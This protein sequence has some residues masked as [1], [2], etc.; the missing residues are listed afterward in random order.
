M[1]WQAVSNKLDGLATVKHAVLTFS[2]T[3]APPGVG[4][5]SDTVNGLNLYVNEDLCF[6]VPVIA[7]WTFGPLGGGLTQPSYQQSVQ[8]AIA[9]ASNW[10]TSNPLQ[11]FALGG[12]SQGAEASS[13]VLMALMDGS[14][15]G[16]DR[17]I[18][19]YTFGNPCRMPGAHAPGIADPGGH[20]I[21][22][23]LM[24]SLPMID[25]R[26]V[27]ADYVHSP[28]NGDPALDM[29]ASVPNGI[30]GQDMSDVYAIA[31]ALQF[32]NL[33]A[34]TS[35]MTTALTKIAYDSGLTDAFDGGLPALLEMGVDFIIGMIEDAIAGGPTA[36]PTPAQAD[37]EAAVEGLRFLAAP[38]G[39]TGPHISYLGEIGGYSNLVQDAV[40]FLHDLAVAIPARAAA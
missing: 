8:D 16:I 23:K 26:V 27:W 7:P 1:G 35:S 14:L 40:G 28:A 24:P 29:Y 17:F 37:G 32:N 22:T 12:Y 30:V 3:W 19:G 9:W 20:G 33:G 21:A 18:G 4:Y 39:P 13:Q 34:L 15:P 36:N 11:T 6:E 38:G 2:G 10:I 5:S 31:T 25:G